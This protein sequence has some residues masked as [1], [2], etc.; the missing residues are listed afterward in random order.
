MSKV[1]KLHVHIFSMPETAKMA[2]IFNR[3]NFLTF[4]LYN[5]EEKTCQPYSCLIF[6][7]NRVNSTAV[8]NNDKFNNYLLTR[9]EEYS[10]IYMKPIT[11]LATAPTILLIEVLN[12]LTPK[13][14]V[15]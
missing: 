7:I 15:R 14:I 8:K 1:S 6:C 5:Q 13:L 3:L 4:N 11:L 9:I 2:C 10:Y 12:Y